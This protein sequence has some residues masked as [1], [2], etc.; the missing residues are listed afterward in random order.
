MKKQ[1]KCPSPEDASQKCKAFNG[2]IIQESDKRY[3]PPHD[4][5]CEC[6]LNDLEKPKKKKSKPKEEPEENIG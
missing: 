3:H 1:I 6:T 5:K 4:S 2:M